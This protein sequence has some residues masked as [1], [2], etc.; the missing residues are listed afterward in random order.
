MSINGT[1]D[2]NDDL[3]SITVRR[4]KRCGGILISRQAIEDG[5]GH[6]CKMKTLEEKNARQPLDG[7]MSLLGIGTEDQDEGGST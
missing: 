7:Q 4:C 5:Y 6:V 2:R 3:F 1:G